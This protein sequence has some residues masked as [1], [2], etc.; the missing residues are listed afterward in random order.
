MIPEYTRFLVLPASREFPRF[1]N[2][3]TGELL[4]ANRLIY[5]NR[6][7]IMKA[8][9]SEARIQV[10]GKERRDMA[11]EKTGQSEKEAKK[12]EKKINRMT[13]PQIEKKL[14]D[15]KGSMGGHASK[16]ARQLLQRKKVLS[17]K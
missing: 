7:V 1:K 13:L 11:D 5:R 3:K 2:K 6:F 4:P 12:R 15:I 10:P 16:Y 14:E 9:Y 17:P 8:R